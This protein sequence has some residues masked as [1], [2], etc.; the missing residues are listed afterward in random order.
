MS[1]PSVPTVADT[2]R[3][4]V[5]TAE[6]LAARLL[7]Q[8]GSHTTGPERRQGKRIARLLADRSGRAFVLALTDEVL[9]IRD[10]RRA[11]RHFR[12]VVNGSARP[13]FLGPLDRLALAGGAA[14]ASALPRVVMPLVTA[15]V[16]GELAPFVRAAEPGP[17]GRYIAGRRSRGSRVNLNLLGEAILGDEEA[18]RRLDE[19]EK[20]LQRPDVDY[21]SVKISSV[22]AQINPVAFDAEVDR[23]A[24]Q[25]RSLYRVASKS[26][27]AKFV[28][29]DMEE[30]RDLHLT[31]AVFRQVLDEELFAAIDAG[32]VLQ[33]Y[34]PD[35]LG[36]LRE[37]LGW[38]VKRHDRSGGR[39]KIRFVKGANLSM[40]QV[41]SELTGWPQAPFPTKMEVDANY[42]RLLDEALRPEYSRAVRVGVASHNLFEVA[43]AL[44]VAEARLVPSM[45]EPEMLEGMAPS[46]AEAVRDAAGGLLYYA[47]IARRD[48]YES[49]ISYLVRR[50]DEN[51][52]PDN[53]LRNQFTL[54]SGSPE[55]EVERRRFEAS[56][57]ARHEPCVTTRL[58][59]DRGAEEH[60]AVASRREG[61]SN[62]PD[63]DFSLAPNREWISRHLREVVEAPLE[64]IPAIV[65]GRTLAAGSPGVVTA[66]GTDPARPDASAY[67]WVQIGEDLAEE[68]VEAARQA[69]ETWR[70]RDA[71]DR[72]ALLR[73]VAAHLSRRRGH[74]VAVMARDGG[75]TLAEADP[76]VSEAIDFARYYSEEAD[77][78]ARWEADGA[79]FE[80][81]GTVAVIPP[82]NFPLAIPAGGV[83]AALAAGSAVLLKPAPETVAVAWALAET[84]W[85]AGIPR[86]LLQFVPC[87]DGE[88][89]RRLVTHEGVDAVILTGSWDTARMF[90]GW[91]PDLRLHA[92]TSGKNALVITAAADL[93]AAIA[94]L[95]R[96]AFGH[97]GQKCSAASLGI[98]EASVHD[99]PRFRR[100]LADAVRT[101]RVGP[102]WD[103]RSTMGPLIQP[104]EGRLLEALQHL[105]PGESWLVEPRPLSGAGGALWS[106][107]VKLG[108]APGSPFHLTEYF[109]PVLGLMR[110]ADLEQAIEWQNGTAYGLT[111]GLHSLDPEEISHWRDRV[112]AGNVYVNRH[113]TGAIVR[114]Q[115]FGGWKRSV[116]GP[117]AKAGGPNYVTSLGRWHASVT[118]DAAAFGSAVHDVLV[119]ELAPTDLSGL[120]AEA[121]VLRYVPLRRVLLRVGNGVTE[122]ELALAL[123]AADAVNVEVVTSASKPLPGA[124]MLDDDHLVAM[125]AEPG[126]DKARLLGS[127][128]DKVRLAAHDA[129]LWVDDVPVVAHPAIEALRWVREQ[130]LSETRHRHGN[131]TG[132][133]G[134]VL[135]TGT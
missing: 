94:D 48:D 32:I 38:A 114:R 40:E 116:V 126:W 79:R 58:T 133:H 46:M 125:F 39:I 35:S 56:V 130:A 93:D 63:T 113:I 74:L 70:G 78:I 132:R 14:V 53:F 51:T 119:G 90:L 17:L 115:P 18:G 23:I 37:L 24:G 109:G 121:N 55:W 16:R 12:S 41:V 6:V 131:I 2:D 85:Q 43:W 89:G 112:E 77:R 26:R 72:A 91:K 128:E 88:V 1:D 20:L 3:Q 4:L 5:A 99:D 80:P 62:E 21:V 7:A 82:W 42:K 111:A 59:Q 124:E 108:V 30:F 122:E 52:G 106:P 15:R 54:R 134:S 92:E 84:C 27:P 75:K 64:E 135:D 49:V 76:E 100:Q 123:A 117:G 127:I 22:C 81:Y 118:T 73:E 13:S 57:S 67:R 65:A 110:A 34:L 96:S 101:L 87:A 28:N 98:I 120:A 44:T 33:A 95:V 83:F 50:F 129:G 71:V 68:A 105:Q 19:V 107:G 10:D 69:G 9:R 103:V 86:E 47:P 61:F 45:I 104:P 8:A 36:A 31:V 11:A 29:L 66:E 97:A 102:G 60:S 25:L